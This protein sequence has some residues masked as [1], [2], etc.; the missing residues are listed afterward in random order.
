M[1]VGE[2][3][4]MPAALIQP[5]FDFIKEWASKKG[6]TLGFSLEEVVKNERVI[7]RIQKEIDQINPQF[8][9]WEQIKKFE[10]TP[11]IW[12]IETGELT[13]TLKLKRKVILE[14]YKDL[15]EKMYL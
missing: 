10:L 13:P 12:S 14:K 5:S 8:G 2:G 7:K 4:K 11:S 1:V 15:Y 3:K 9:K 6:L